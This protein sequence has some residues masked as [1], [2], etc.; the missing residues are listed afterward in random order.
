MASF[1]SA[2]TKG[3]V[4]RDVSIR[5]VIDPKEGPQLHTLSKDG[6][7]LARHRLS[8]EEEYDFRDQLAERPAPRPDPEPEPRPEPEPEPQ[9]RPAAVTWAADASKPFAEEWAAGNAFDVNR[10]EGTKGDNAAFA[11]STRI[12]RTVRG[13]KP[14]WWVTVADGDQDFHGEGNQR[15][16]MGQGSPP[17][18]MPDGVE[19]RMLPGT[20]H[21]LAYELLIPASYPT[22]AS[23]CALNQIKGAANSGNGP[24]AFDFYNGKLLFKKSLSQDQTSQNTG[25]LWQ[26]PKPVPR[27]VWIK[28]LV[29]VQWSLGADG[30][31]AMWADLADGHGLVERV[32][33]TTGWT[34]KNNS[35]LAI[36]QR[37][38][39]YRKAIPGTHSVYF[40]GV[41]QATIREAATR[42]AF[43]A[44]L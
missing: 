23:W 8:I 42:H 20:E 10:G 16:E 26:S 3:V 17:R 36:G 6:V 25:V 34:L 32:R 19:R 5:R 41:C 24:L 31:V 9:P 12:Q 22:I 30:H 38:G 15:T 4:Q 37:L 43:G 27:D 21:W 11:R 14:C 39:I 28:V 44:A 40:A 29:N 1:R 18:K 7:V 33:R 13:G 2:T 35:D